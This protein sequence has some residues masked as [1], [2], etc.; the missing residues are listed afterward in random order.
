M[1]VIEL[2]SD[3]CKCYSVELSRKILELFEKYNKEYAYDVES[4]GILIG[5]V[6]QETRRIVIEDITEPYEADKRTRYN[7][8]RSEKGHQEYM[9]RVWNESGHELTYI[10]EWH[11]HNQK[12]IQA[13]LIDINNWKRI[14]KIQHN[15]NVLVFI[16]LGRTD[17]KVWI[18][19]ST[20]INEFEGK[21]LLNEEY[22]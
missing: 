22:N 11:T 12:K 14:S 16:I 1:Q 15:T 6:N 7:F 21:L 3:N 19:N 20:K 8:V 4:G 5:K 18:S 17:Y 10:G 9:D 13:S 2:M